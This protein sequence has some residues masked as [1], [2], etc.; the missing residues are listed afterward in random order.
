M[1]YRRALPFMSAGSRI[2]NIASAWHP[3]SPAAPGRIL[4]GKTVYPGRLALADAELG[5][6]D[7]HVTAVCP[8][9]MDTEFLSSPG[10]KRTARR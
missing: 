10:D 6:V 5:D 1:M 8:K 4:C 2:I 9:F 7:I 3:S